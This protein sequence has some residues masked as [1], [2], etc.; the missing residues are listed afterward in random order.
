MLD[1]TGVVER[2]L[3]ALLR[4]HVQHLGSSPET[5][6]QTL[7]VFLDGPA[8]EEDL[9]A[10]AVWDAP[11]RAT[12]A[13][14]DA[15]DIDKEV[16]RSAAECALQLAA[17]YPGQQF[18]L[19]LTEFTRACT[20]EWVK[21]Y[22][23]RFSCKERAAQ[24]ARPALPAGRKK[25]ERTGTDAAVLRGQKRAL[26]RTAAAAAGPA[27]KSLKTLFGTPVG[28]KTSSAA[29]PREKRFE[30]F[31]DDTAKKH[32]AARERQRRRR[33]GQ[34]PYPVQKF[35]K[36]LHCEAVLPSRRRQQRVPRALQLV[37]S[38][39]AT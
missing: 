2:D 32:A 35:R 14:P 16:A 19:R 36:H 27:A 21:R 13:C 37:P 9:V 10:S 18:Q 24:K 31:Q 7:L 11:A 8:R 26:D 39:R 38:L 23:R 17:A 25:N 1:N 28:W 33:A 4:S 6:E 12:A 22:G 34:N 5:L 30:K 15:L 29:C 20:R 3:G